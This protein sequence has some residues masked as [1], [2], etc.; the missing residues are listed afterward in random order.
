MNKKPS[1]ES[2]FFNL[3]VLV[4]LCAVGALLVFVAFGALP[5]GHAVPQQSAQNQNSGVAQAQKST[6]DNPSSPASAL[7]PRERTSSSNF[8][9]ME[10]PGPNGETCLL[11]TSDAAD[12]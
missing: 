12:E 11:Y 8:T 4:V 2:A 7:S 3:R 6:N 10:G 5:G 9:L 1:S